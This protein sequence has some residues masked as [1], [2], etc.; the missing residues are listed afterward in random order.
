MERINCLHLL[1]LSKGGIRQHFLTIIDT[2]RE[3]P[4]NH[5][6]CGP[7]DDYLEKELRKRSL[8]YNVLHWVNGREMK[9]IFKVTKAV[10]KII[11]A[12]K[13]KLIHAHGHKMS[14][15]GRLASLFNSQIKTIVTL[16]NFSP[17]GYAGILL[18]RVNQCLDNRTAK[19]IAVSQALIDEEVLPV[20][21]HKTVVIYNGIDLT[22]FKSEKALPL[23]VKVIG[24]T[25]RLAPQKGLVFLLKAFQQLTQQ[26]PQ[27]KLHIIGEGPEK[28]FL[29]KSASQLG[30]AEKTCFLGN[31]SNIIPAL[32][33][34]D[35][36]VMPSVS[37]GL[38]IAAIEA[39]ALKKPVVV[40]NTGGLREVVEA[41]RSGL[42]VE[43]GNDRL[44]AQ[45]INRLVLNVDLRK[46]LSI[47]GRKRAEELFDVKQMLS[48][49][50]QMYNE[51]LSKDA[52]VTCEGD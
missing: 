33:E 32:Q 38:S 26:F 25:A 23:E 22:R 52:S 40:S 49:T 43:P 24:T 11:V 14:L 42:L 8:K 17:L 2:L 47:N 44:L 12:N 45:A 27:L 5:F 29:E 48:R 51:L 19:I 4:V 36:F 1:P 13:I 35:I 15:A 31:V 37:E 7:A 21:Y 9:N 39:L 20:N 41:N 16:H 46:S 30:I 18:K 34:I 10:K 28:A 6:V 3:L 50:K